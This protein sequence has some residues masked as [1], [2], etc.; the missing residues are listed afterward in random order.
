MF[1]F[2]DVPIHSVQWKALKAKLEKYARKEKRKF[3]WETYE[4]LADG[5]TIAE[6]RIAR[7]H[8]RAIVR[9]GVYKGRKYDKDVLLCPTPAAR[10][11]LFEDMIDGK[12]ICVRGTLA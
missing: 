7:R 1:T 4:V 12:L 5:T 8:S 3:T 2:K 10:D 6:W 9:T 11:A